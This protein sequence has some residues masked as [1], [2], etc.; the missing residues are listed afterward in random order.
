[1][2]R[3]HLAVG[4]RSPRSPPACSCRS[5]ARRPVRPTSSARRTRCT[6]TGTAHDLIVPAG[7]F[8]AVTGATI[9]HDLILQDGAGAECRGTSIGHDV[10]FG[11]DAGGGHRRVDRRPRHRRRRDR[12]RAPTS[13]DRSIGHDFVGAGEDS[14]SDLLRVDGR[15]RHAAARA[16]RRDAHGR[17]DDRPRL[18]R[19]EAADGAD[20]A[21]TRPDTPGGPVNVGHDFTIEGSP[22]L[23]FVFDGLCD[24]HVANDLRDHRPHG[25]SRHRARRQ[26]AGNG[27]PAEHDRPR[28]GRDGQHA[29]R[30]GS[31]ARR[32]STSA[33]TT[34]AAISCSA[35]TRRSRAGR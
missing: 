15:A 14:G 6:F 5:R 28:P 10:V 20:R 4:R 31:S 19:V 22:D 29:P 21:Q 7:G 11:E 8:C 24:L 16:R 35:T 32:R 9:T 26:C 27:E 17:V 12:I 23:P 30:P 2:K 25:Q 3:A 34:S 18:L 33:P 1:M 13:P